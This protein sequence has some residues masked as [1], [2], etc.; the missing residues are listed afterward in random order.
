[1]YAA[2]F[3]VLGTTYGVGNG[4]STFN[5]PDLRSRASIG[6]G[7]AIQK[8]SDQAPSGATNHPLGQSCGEETHWLTTTE[9]PSHVHAN[10]HIDDDVL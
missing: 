2:L 4:S 10:E 6:V 1:M 9:L 3:A 7:T 8:G 5:V